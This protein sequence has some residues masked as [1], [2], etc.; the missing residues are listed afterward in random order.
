MLT[1]LD[2]GSIL[3]KYFKIENL[4]SISNSISTSISTKKKD[5]SEAN[6]V[7]QKY[8]DRVPV[9]VTK[10]QYSSTTPEIDKQKFLVPVDITMG[11]LLYVIRKRLQ[12]HPETRLFLFIDGTMI[13]NHEL[14]GTVYE[15][16][17]D[18]EDGF[19][20]AVYSCESVFGGR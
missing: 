9:L 13:T 3:N 2:T 5:R 20:H 10:N 12:L 11:Q 19:L 16:L 8:P 17:H 4:T 1:N 15:R 14:I 7:L 6:R 18:R